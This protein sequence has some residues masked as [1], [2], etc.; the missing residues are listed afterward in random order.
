MAQMTT[1]ESLLR[2]HLQ[3]CG[4]MSWAEVMQLA[5]YHP[6]VGYYRYPRRIGRG[7]DFYTAVSVGPL[8]GRLL[9]QLALQTWQRCGSPAEFWLMEQGAHDGQLA[10][11][12]WLALKD[13]PLSSA[14]HYCVLE[15]RPSYLEVLETRLRPLLGEK[16]HLQ[17]QSTTRPCGLLLWNEL[18]D[19]LPCERLRWDGQQWQQLGIQL[20]SAAELTWCELHPL[21]APQLPTDLPVGY[22]TELNLHLPEV[23]TQAAALLERG[24]FYIADYGYTAEEYYHVDRP[25]GTLRRY[26]QHRT[27][28]KVLE[29]LGE[30]DLTAHIDFTALISTLEPQGWI[31]AEFLDQGR[32]L[33]RL[34]QPWLLSMDGQRPTPDSLALLR[35]FQTLTHPS[36][37]GS[38]FRCLLM[39]R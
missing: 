29:A 19:A 14:L 15:E 20:D 11:D 39:Q 37:M 1:A 9:A 3:Q 28:D 21:P 27:D 26:H 12:I 33:T 7:G 24:A 36:H 32:F 10:E 6:Q 30:A 25:T 17:A 35:Q 38:A 4:P 31:T 23:A 8:Y 5:L 13:S 18:A 34:A 22:T 16:L 2:D